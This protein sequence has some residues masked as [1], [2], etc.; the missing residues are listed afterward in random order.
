[1]LCSKGS[2]EAVCTTFKPGKKRQMCLNIAQYINNA[3]DYHSQQTV[4]CLDE[5]IFRRAVELI[6]IFSKYF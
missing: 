1:M 6:S 3:V 4:L 5:N 2:N